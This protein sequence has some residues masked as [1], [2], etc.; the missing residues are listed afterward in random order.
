[1][2][3]TFSLEKKQE[4]RSLFDWMRTFF[5]GLCMGTADIVPGISGGTVAFIMGFYE[6]L[7]NSIRGI[8]LN[9]P[10]LLHFR[11]RLFYRKAPWRFLLALGLGICSAI[12]MLASLVD[13]ILGHEIFRVYLYAAFFGL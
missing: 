12:A 1:M 9:V 7:I 4:L 10:L 3:G 11:F 2:S 13:L 5:F 6:D 8:G